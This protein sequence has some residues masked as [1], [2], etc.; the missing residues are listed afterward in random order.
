MRQYEFVATTHLLMDAIPV[1]THL[2]MIFQSTDIDIAIVQA[3]IQTT[4]T[5]LTALTTSNGKFLSD[6]EKMKVANNK[7]VVSEAGQGMALLV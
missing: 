5:Q 3:S 7:Y 4:T 6:L 2:S 1:L